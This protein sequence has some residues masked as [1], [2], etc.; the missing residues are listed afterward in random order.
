M[1][2][3]VV[4]K[5]AKLAAVAAAAALALGLGFTAGTAQAY[6][7]EAQADLALTTQMNVP[8]ITGKA[9]AK[10]AVNET[11]TVVVTNSV[12][13]QTGIWSA[14]SSSPAN[15]TAAVSPAKVT[16]PAASSK[17]TVTITGIKK[18]TAQITVTF[19]TDSGKKS[20]TTIDVTVKGKGDI[21]TPTSKAF[22]YV[23]NDDQK[24]TVEVKAVKA[25]TVAASVPSKVTDPETGATYKVTHIGQESFK[26]AKS[27]LTSVKLPSTIKVIRAKAFKNCNKITKVTGAKKVVRINDNAFYNCTKMTK[28]E[29]FTKSTKL[30][31]I[32]IRSFGKVRSMVNPVVTSKKLK[33]IGKQAFYKALK[34]KTITL[35]STSLTKKGVKACLSG[36]QTTKLLVAKKS[37]IPYFLNLSTLKKLIVKVF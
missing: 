15:A 12:A 14:T 37:Y 21:V 22:T 5:K 34:M 18:G 16:T 31:K 4:M 17:T 2:E 3:V 10:V 23:I 27:T 32:G 9:A 25:G 1:G 11:T 7:D 6:A 20:V 29:P 24:E 28:C 8:N 19:T 35:K 13:N 36:A 26:A 33:T 30:E